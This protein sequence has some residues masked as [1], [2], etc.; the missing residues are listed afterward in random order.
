MQTKKNREQ[1]GTRLPYYNRAVHDVQI[2]A[3]RAL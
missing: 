2:P 3:N 1:N